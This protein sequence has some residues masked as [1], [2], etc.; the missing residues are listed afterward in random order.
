[1]AIKL[2]KDEYGEA[3]PPAFQHCEALTG[4][5]TKPGVI[6]QVKINTSTV[7]MAGCQFLI[8]SKLN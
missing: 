2:L 7:S 1:M 8:K 3:E 6:G 5:N 4:Q